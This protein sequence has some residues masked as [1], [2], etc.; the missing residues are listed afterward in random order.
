MVEW[1]VMQTELRY[2]FRDPLTAKWVPLTLFAAILGL[3]PYLGS[4]YIAIA[5][6]TFIG[7]EPQYVNSLHRWPGH[8]AGHAILPVSWD[9][10]IRGK[11]LATIF[12]TVLV[13]GVV[14][15]LALFV[16]PD[17]PSW[18]ESEHAALYLV[19]TVPLLLIAGNALT[20]R[21]ART[22][23]GVEFGDAAAAL[24]MMVAA[25]F[26]SLPFVV[27]V[28]ALKLMW[29]A[30]LFALFAIFLWAWFSIPHTARFVQQNTP[31]LCQTP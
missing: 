1:T 24:Q 7:M 26:C 25:L 28:Y 16:T 11:N 29:A 15:I 4:V 18:T 23:A 9:R 10:I 30:V 8:F 3:W 21:E 27:L 20:G 14:S 17:R 6:V 5:A 12:E 2:F 22:G 31:V 13:F 19:M